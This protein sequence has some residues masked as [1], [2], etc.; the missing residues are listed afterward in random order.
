MVK[1][2]AKKKKKKEV[3]KVCWVV[4]GD[5]LPMLILALCTQFL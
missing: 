1:G 4:A 2:F 5:Y 3:V